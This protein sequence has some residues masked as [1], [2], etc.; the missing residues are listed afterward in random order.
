MT[1]KSNL[2]S[3]FVKFVD[4]VPLITNSSI[5]GPPEMSACGPCSGTETNS[6]EHG[7]LVTTL[8][9]VNRVR[10]KFAYV[11]VKQPEFG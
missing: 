4:S 3:Q 1:T 2:L 10:N 11:N 8:A 6:A 5:R 7:L 9:V